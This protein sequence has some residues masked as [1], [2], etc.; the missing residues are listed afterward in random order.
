MVS[1]KIKK[2]LKKKKTGFWTSN[3][4]K[5]H[6]RHHIIGDIVKSYKLEAN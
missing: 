4:S 5:E 3:I 6:M 1:F 2:K